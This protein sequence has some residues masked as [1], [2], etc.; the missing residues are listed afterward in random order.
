MNTYRIASHALLI[1]AFGALLLLIWRPVGTWWQWTL[2]AILCVIAAA[3]FSNA[4]DD[5]EGA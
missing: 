2:T 5:Q 4:A 3:G 1:A